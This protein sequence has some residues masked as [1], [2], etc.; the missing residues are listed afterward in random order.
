MSFRA[1][2][3]E[4]ALSNSTPGAHADG[5]DAAQQEVPG[6]AYLIA[7]AIDRVG[8]GGVASM[9]LEIGKPLHWL[10]GQVAWVLEPILGSFGPFSRKGSMPIESIARLLERPEGATEL[11]GQLEAMRGKQ[12]LGGGGE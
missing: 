4:Q 11:A 10:G 5:G 3:S 12:E 1:G 7:R 8:M 9:A 2:R 6:D